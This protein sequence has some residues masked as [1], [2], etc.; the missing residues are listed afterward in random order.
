MAAMET[1]VFI[2]HG[3][4][5]QRVPISNG[6]QLYAAITKA[7]KRFYPISGHGHSQPDSDDFYAAVRQ[8]LQETSLKAA[9]PR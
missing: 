8:F 4:E 7:P 9:N 5:D 6:E 2:A 3:T 1:P